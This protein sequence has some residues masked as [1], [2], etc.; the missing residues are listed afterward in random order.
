MSEPARDHWPICLA[1]PAAT[2]E[3]WKSRPLA[4][5]LFA[6][7]SP[8]HYSQTNNHLLYAFDFKKEELYV[9]GKTSK[10]SGLTQAKVEVL[11]LIGDAHICYWSTTEGV[12]RSRLLA[13]AYAITTAYTDGLVKDILYPGTHVT[14]DSKWRAVDE[15]TRKRYFHMTFPLNYVGA[16]DTY[17][18]T[19]HRFEYYGASFTARMIEPVL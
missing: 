9:D 14:I 8:Y 5:P 17:V 3:W 6:K 16:L 18:V 11:T 15:K 12:R 13:I 2:T 1:V 7:A 4:I 10:I 19:D